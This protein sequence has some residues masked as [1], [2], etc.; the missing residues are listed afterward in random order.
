[1]KK[2]LPRLTLMALLGI[3]TVFFI[4]ALY[5]PPPLLVSKAYLPKFQL[6]G[7]EGQPLTW[8]TLRGQVSILHIWAPWC[9]VCRADHQRLV[10]LLAHHAVPVYGI[11]YKSYPEEVSQWLQGQPSLYK[12]TGL[13]EQGRLLIDLGLS[14]VPETFIIGPKLNIIYRQQGLIDLD[15][16]GQQLTQV[17]EAQHA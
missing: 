4:K 5:R 1:M 17:L 11:A 6:A 8:Q 12:Q 15:V 16:F 14:T 9:Y 7:L 13:D 10:S 3:S 2:M